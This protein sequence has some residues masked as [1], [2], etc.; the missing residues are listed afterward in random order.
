MVMGRPRKPSATQEMS[1][2]W[3][4]NAARRRVDAQTE[5]P[6]DV[7]NPPPGLS[8]HE[9]ELWR[10]IIANAP[11]RVLKNSD[12]FVVEALAKAMTEVRYPVGLTP[13]QRNA[14]RATVKGMLSLLGMTPADRSR[15][16]S[17]YDGSPAG[18]GDDNDN[19]FKRH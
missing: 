13:S 7:N 16:E 9:L 3:D 12:K 17:G 1:G 2:A 15:V 18:D 11:I 6:L 4:H 14:S 10:D 5:A 8:E 19:E